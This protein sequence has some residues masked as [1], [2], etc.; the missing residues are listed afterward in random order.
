MSPRRSPVIVSR[1][2]GR[3]AYRA[4]KKA[5]MRELNRLNRTLRNIKGRASY[6]SMAASWHLEGMAADHD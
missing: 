3:K 4:R 2:V 6:W 1:G 5:A